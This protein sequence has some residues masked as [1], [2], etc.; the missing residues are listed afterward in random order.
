M[1]SGTVGSKQSAGARRGPAKNQSRVATLD[2]VWL[3]SDDIV[4][5][6][7]RL[8][9]VGPIEIAT[10]KIRFD[11]RWGYLHCCK[12]VWENK[13]PVKWLLFSLL[14]E[15]VSIA[16]FVIHPTHVEFWRAWDWNPSKEEES[17]IDKTL[18]YLRSRRHILFFLGE[19]GWQGVLALVALV[20]LLAAAAMHLRGTP[21]EL[22]TMSGIAT[23]VIAAIWAIAGQFIPSRSHV[24]LF[25][26]TREEFK[27]RVRWIASRALGAVVIFV[28]GLLLGAIFG[29]RLGIGR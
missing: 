2:T 16:T 14:R 11:T 7:E 10:D 6:A 24:T 20:L 1:V 15:R 28:V 17:A 25:A 19:S 26:Y 8:A 22:L 23:G 12:R 5:L 18:D 13:L 4:A 27:R 29:P 9:R 21:S 3:F